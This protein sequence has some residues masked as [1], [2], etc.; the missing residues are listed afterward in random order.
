[1]STADTLQSAWAKQTRSRVLHFA[2]ECAMTTPTSLSPEAAVDELDDDPSAVPRGGVPTQESQDNADI[3]AVEL[4]EFSDFYR[5]QAARL[6]VFLMAMGAD[7]QCANDVAQESMV[8]MWRGWSGIRTPHAY[9]RVVA[10]RGLIRRISKASYNEQ[11][12]DD[13]ESDDPD[14][15]L[16]D[17]LDFIIRNAEHQSVL[18]RI[19]KL[20]PRQRQVIAWTYDGYKP[21][22]I[23]EILKISSETVRASLLK[24]RKALQRMREEEEG[25]R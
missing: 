11:S 1:M 19:R 15:A 3:H 17:P 21:I 24:A 5:S 25:G 8:A 12:L 2:V 6:I 7:E 23:A 22:E 10:T 9:V 16:A 4:L 20:P 14:R 13:R 18:A